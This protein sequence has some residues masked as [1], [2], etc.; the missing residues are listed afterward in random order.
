MPIDFHWQLATEG[1]ARGR[2][3]ADPTAAP[4]H[5]IGVAQAAEHAGFQALL[6]PSGVQRPDAWL[7][8]TTLA[9]HTERLRF[10]V[11][12]RPGFVLP[13]AAAQSVQ[14]LQELSGHRLMLTVLTGDIADHHA[15]GDAVN[16]DD[17]FDRASEF[18]RLLRLLC[19]G[20]P[21]AGGLHHQG[22]HYRVEC[23]GLLRPLREAPLLCIGG[24]SPA[25]ERVAAEH[26]DLHLHWA[27]PLEAVAERARRLQALAATAGR[28]LRLGLR[29]HVIAQEREADAWRQ[30]GAALHEAGLEARA[31]ALEIAPN[32]W[33]GYGALRGRPGTAAAPARG[34]AA[35]VGSY[36]QVAERLAEYQAAGIDSFLLSGEA[37]LEDALRFGEEL[38]PL[39]RSRMNAAPEAVAGDDPEP[40]APAASARRAPPGATLAGARTSAARAG[41]L[42]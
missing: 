22:T 20:R 40:A 34:G 12:L 13:A 27:E 15:Y 17:R 7:V 1:D 32:L 25:G 41:T 35:L 4:A 24:S 3:D 23:G 38:L 10:I 39:A 36:A 26:A 19:R 5:W 16:H 42:S 28:P 8:A 9:R 11:G 2:I 33:A 37:G 21:P 29:L 6:V 14:T 31:R 30:A 18:L